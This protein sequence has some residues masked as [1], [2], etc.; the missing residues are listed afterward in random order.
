MLPQK[1]TCAPFCTEDVALSY[2]LDYQMGDKTRAKDIT[3]SASMGQKARRNLREI[4]GED[5]AIWNTKDPELNMVYP[6]S[7]SHQNTRVQPPGCSFN[8]IYS[9]RQLFTEHQLQPII[10]QLSFTEAD[11]NK[12]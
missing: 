4:K 3:V 9:T 2:K 1:G 11:S 6:I 8:I 12:G 7:S 5:R 10:T